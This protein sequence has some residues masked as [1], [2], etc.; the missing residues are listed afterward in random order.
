MDKKMIGRREEQAL[1]K[2]R[3]LSQE[4]EFIAIYG[5]RRVGKTYLIKETIAEMKLPSLEASGLKD[6]SL[7]DQLEIFM[8][9]FEKTFKPI[10]SLSPPSSWIEAFSILTKAI[11]ALPKK[12]PFVIFL[13]EL[14]WFATAKSG[15][16]QALDHFWNTEWVNRPQIKFIACGSAASWMID[17]LIKAKGGLHNRLTMSLLLRPFNLKESIE[18]LNSRS[19]RLSLV[20]A[21]DLY[22]VMGGIPYYLKAVEKG[23]SATENI[24]QLCFTQSGLLFGEFERLYSSLFQH[25]EATIEIIK[26]LA[27]KPQGVSRSELENGLKRSSSGGTLTK[28]LVELEAAGF[29]ISFIPY[30]RE[31]KGIYYRIID[32]YTLFYLRFVKPLQTRIKLS[33]SS[34]NYWQNKSQSMEWKS[35]SGFAFEAFCYKHIDQ[36]ARALKV[37]TG[38][39]VGTWRYLPKSKQEKGVQIDLL[40]DSDEG[41]IHIIEIKYS[42]S[43]FRITKQYATQLGDKLDV[44][45]EQTKAKKDLSLSMITV[46]GL[47]END[48]AEEL[49]DKRIVLEDLVQ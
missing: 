41:T 38:F 11:D 25:S 33:T 13:D 37:S 4:A 2:K 22:L 27:K 29:I 47:V 31:K 35:W 23:L 17:H 24:N 39:N 20:Q 32:E 6:G 10:Y 1:L 15:L 9:A 21:L 30:G 43:P 26:L 46:S 7:R 48:Y 19:I 16:L 40:L 12:K 14:P 49:I 44:F 28:R 5:R 42:K 36:I 45:Q 18:L 8:R 34:N 3:L